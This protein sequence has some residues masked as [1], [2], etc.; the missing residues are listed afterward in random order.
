MRTIAALGRWACPGKDPA[1]VGGS[2]N[3]TIH[4]P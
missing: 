2:G 1:G 4:I 3:V